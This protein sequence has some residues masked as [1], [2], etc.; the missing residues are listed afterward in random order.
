MERW[1]TESVIALCGLALFPVVP[2]FP[3]PPHVI[4]I[5]VRKLGSI[6]LFIMC[7]AML[8]NLSRSHLLMV[9]WGSPTLLSNNS[10]QH[11]WD[12]SPSR[13]RAKCLTWTVSFTSQKSYEECIIIIRTLQMSQIM[14]VTSYFF[15]SCPLSDLNMEIRAEIV[16]YVSLMR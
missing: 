14:F 15:Y 5:N 9:K 1:W 6:S 7:L 11:L 10:D 13:P 2:P 3:S 16:Y 8:F 4:I 12:F